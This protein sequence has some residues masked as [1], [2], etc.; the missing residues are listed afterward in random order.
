MLT[1]T[2]NH[3]QHW[4]TTLTD[5]QCCHFPT[6]DTTCLHTVPYYTTCHTGGWSI[7]VTNG[8][9]KW[10]WISSVGVGLPVVKDVDGG[11]EVGGG[12]LWWWRQLEPRAGAKN[13]DWDMWHYLVAKTVSFKAFTISKVKIH[14]CRWHFHQTYIS[15][16]IVYKYIYIYA[17]QAS[18]HWEFLIVHSF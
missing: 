4:P 1:F 7:E 9:G 16:Y 8:R 11:R 17:L 5:W 10:R 15:I 14:F 13:Q 12:K 3:C 18:K 2:L 6:L